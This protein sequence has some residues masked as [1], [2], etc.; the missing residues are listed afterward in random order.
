MLRC[1]ALEVEKVSNRGRSLLMFFFDVFRIRRY[2][3]G[4]SS[5]G[6]PSAMTAAIWCWE[7]EAERR[8]PESVEY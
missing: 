3:D 2:L 7:A 8:E 6:R 4:M 5:P 1:Q